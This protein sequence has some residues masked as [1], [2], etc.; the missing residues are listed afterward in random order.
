MGLRFGSIDLAMGRIDAGPDAE[1]L[2][3]FQGTGRAASSRAASIR[4]IVKRAYLRWDHEPRRYMGS[5]REIIKQ[6]ANCG[7]YSGAVTI[8][9]PRGQAATGVRVD[10]G[11]YDVRQG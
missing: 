6:M 3:P 1:K 8:S 7:G 4:P 2:H 9:A 5:V 11:D 10:P